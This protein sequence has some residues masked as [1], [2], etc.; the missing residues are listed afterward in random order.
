MAVARLRAAVWESIFTHDM[1]RYQRVLFDRMGDFTT[2]IVGESGTGKELVAQ[3]IALSRF[4]PFDPKRGAFSEDFTALF[5]GLN[6]SALSPTLIES[7]LFGHRRG[8]FTG[9]LEDRAGWLETCKPLGT[10]F[11]DEIGE[12][13][14]AIQVKL[15]RVLQSRTF[16]RLGDNQPRHFSGKIMAATNR[17]LAR[18]MSAGAFRKDFYY[19]LCS[20]IIQTPSLREQLNECPQDLGQM[21]L[22]I[23]KR[24]AG[25][26]ADALCEEIA[27]WIP[28]N[29]GQTYP[30]PGNFRELEQCVRN[31]VIRRDYRPPSPPPNPNPRPSP[32]PSPLEP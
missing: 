23:V 27:K 10:V 8:A 24:I 28:K 9:A 21:I 15:L 22:F 30:W 17:D 18:E 4:I 3:A 26:E 6:L 1:Q 16:Q 14:G 7:E 11:L 25:E 5:I 12:L 32:T 20:D 13:D 19:R 2:L 29:L 31:W